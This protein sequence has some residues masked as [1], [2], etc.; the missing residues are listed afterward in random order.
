MHHYIDNKD[1]CKDQELFIKKDD[2]LRKKITPSTHIHIEKIFD[3]L[4]E[5]NDEE[6]WDIQN[7]EE[8]DGKLIDY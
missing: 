1:D 6:K 8:Q 5:L 2:I 7:V 3:F 4:Q